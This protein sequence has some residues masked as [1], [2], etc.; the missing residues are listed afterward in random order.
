MAHTGFSTPFLVMPSILLAVLAVAARFT[1]EFREITPVTSRCT[2]YAVTA[3]SQFTVMYS[4]LDIFLKYTPLNLSTLKLIF[5]V[6]APICKVLLDLP[7]T[8]QRL[9]VWHSWVPRAIPEISLPTSLSMSLMKILDKTGPDLENW[10]TLL[11]I[12]PFWKATIKPPV[13]AFNQFSSK[14]TTTSFL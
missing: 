5:H 10:K 7:S 3:S 12:L 8:A 4:R 9:T 13:F 14:T 2:S 11:L 1:H 6:F